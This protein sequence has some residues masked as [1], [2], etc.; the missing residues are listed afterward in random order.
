MWENNKITG[1]I[2]R[3]VI[4]RQWKK[5]I[6]NCKLAIKEIGYH[7]KYEVKKILIWRIKTDKFRISRETIKKI[8]GTP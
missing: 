8:Y 1:R 5:I 7:W 3:E 6:Y 2:Y 4:K